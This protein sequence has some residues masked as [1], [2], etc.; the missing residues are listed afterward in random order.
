MLGG[1]VS[2]GSSAAGAD[3]TAD[4]K[5][6]RFRAAIY[7]VI[8][9]GAPQPILDTDVAGITTLDVHNLDLFSLQGI[10]H[11][12]S[13]EELDCCNNL[14]YGLDV[15][16]LPLTVLRCSSNYLTE[17]AVIGYSGALD[18]VSGFLPQNAPRPLVTGVWSV[19][20]AGYAGE[21]LPLNRWAVIEPGNAAYSRRLYWSIV[22][23]GTT[24]AYM[25][26]EAFGNAVFVVSPGTVTVKSIV[27]NG[28]GPNLDY[29]Q[30]HTIRILAPGSYV[31]VKEITGV[32]RLAFTGVPLK[33]TATVEPADAT[34]K[35]IVWGG[36]DSYMESGVTGD[37]FLAKYPGTAR[38]SARIAAGSRLA[39]ATAAQEM[40]SYDY[41]NFLV[42]RQED[43]KPVTKITGVPARIGLNAS[44][45]LDDIIAAVV[46]PA[47]ATFSNILWSLEDSG[48]AEVE[49][50]NYYYQSI[51]A[52]K[53]GRFKLRATIPE[54]AGLGKDYV[55]IFDIEARK[56]RQ[57][58]YWPAWMQW[59]LK[60]ILFGW[61]W[62]RWF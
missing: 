22:D 49:M 38:V 7:S 59:I 45:R 12:V 17:D 42:M 8:G 23:A 4:F 10:E 27:Y 57:W 44:Y 40:F 30:T 1:I 36:G 52:Y 6:P 43:F 20:L 21:E 53:P 33:L 3:I 32:P 25:I 26:D 28:L 48:A 31:P 61:L 13:L 29:E 55:Q 35:E 46:A 19:P 51:V 9:K 50:G 37:I 47:D 34:F 39:T 14:L 62:M 15:T 2:F 24:G 18:Y 56:I 54:G 41:I 60:Y 5:D 11:F 58:D 16:G